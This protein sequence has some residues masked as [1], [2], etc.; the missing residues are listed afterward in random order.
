VEP[1]RRP[2]GDGETDEVLLCRRRRR[3]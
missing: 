3:A 1:I 2:I